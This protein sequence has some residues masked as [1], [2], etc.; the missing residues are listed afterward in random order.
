MS[1]SVFETFVRQWGDNAITVDDLHAVNWIKR[2]IVG[3]TNLIN[4][5]VIFCNQKV[6]TVDMVGDWSDVLADCSIADSFYSESDPA[7]EANLPVI[8]QLVVSLGCQLILNG[9][10]ESMSLNLL[11][12]LIAK[13]DHVTVVRGVTTFIPEYFTA[14]IVLV[15]RSVLQPIRLVRNDNE[16]TDN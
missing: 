7:Y 15:P 3:T 16:P 2:H 9:M 6:S 14:G 1:K 5:P 8:N 11:Q 12:K 10:V 13:K 4:H